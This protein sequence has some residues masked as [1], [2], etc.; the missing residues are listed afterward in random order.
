MRQTVI[1]QLSSFLLVCIGVQITWN[2]MKALLESVTVH[3]GWSDASPGGSGTAWC[4]TTMRDLGEIVNGLGCCG[5]GGFE[6]SA[7]AFARAA[8]LKDG[9]ARHEDLGASAHD[10][11]DCVVMDAAV[12][13]NAK[14]QAARFAE[15]CQQLDFLQGRADEGLASEAGIH[16]HYQD[17]V[18]ERKNLVEGVDWSGGVYCYAGFASMGG[19]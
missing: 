14:N 5:A 1:V 11:C 8:V 12:Y 3:I 4:A 19:D 15:F 10:V 2:G 13:C 18:N 6:E 9:A 17:M 16:A 7:G